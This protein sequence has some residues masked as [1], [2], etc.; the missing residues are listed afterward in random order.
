MLASSARKKIR[1][2][3][4]EKG[5]TLEALAKVCK[6]SPALLSR[7]ETGVVDPSLSTLMAI[8][9]ALEMRVYE[10]FSDDSS[11][12]NDL[13]CQI[14]PEE[15]K[16]L[17]LRGK[18]QFQLLSCGVDVPFEFVLVRFPPRTSAG[19][20]VRTH[21]GSDLR[22]HEGTECGLVLEGELEVQVEEKIYHL[23]PGDSIT[24]TSST[25]HKISN[26]G[27]EEAL[28]IWID[29]RPFIFSVL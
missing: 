24:L 8:A 26:P 27:N 11:K 2:L 4:K 9:D 14:G 18:I 17:F 23:K 25:P 6:C 15:R 28:A 16:T 22:A 21:D 3:R 1:D 5:L 13:H 19:I 7:I 20:D 12:N 29:S 10:L